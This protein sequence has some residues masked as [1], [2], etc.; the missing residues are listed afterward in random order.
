MWTGKVGYGRHKIL[1]LTHRRQP[2]VVAARGTLKLGVGDVDG[3]LGPHIQNNDKLRHWIQPGMVNTQRLG[4][5]YS[6]VDGFR[7]Q[8]EW[9][10]HGETYPNTFEGPDVWVTVTVPA[11]IHRVS[12]YET[13]K[14]GHNWDN[15][16]RDYVVDI[17][18]YRAKIEDAMLLP[19]L[20]HA[21]IHDFW[22][23]YYTS[24]VTRGPAQYYIHVAKNNSLN[25]LVA[26]VFIDKMA[27]PTTR[28]D[29]LPMAFMSVVHFDPPPAIMAPSDTAPVKAAQKVWTAMDD[30]IAFSS[31]YSF[32][33]PYR[34]L[35]YRS[36][37]DSGVSSDSVKNWQWN[38]NLWTEDDRLWFDRNMQLAHTMQTKYPHMMVY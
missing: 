33:T 30:A 12:L 28:F 38:L 36:A 9:D 1:L 29:K 24:F 10:D 4:T 8:A 11:G 18:P 5:L 27:G 31:D 20:A 25:T 14:D 35:A 32:W 17:L 3:S 2:G 21:R 37:L 19:P 7:T 26:G 16:N 23:G 13:N 22:N 6:P 34:V 15:R